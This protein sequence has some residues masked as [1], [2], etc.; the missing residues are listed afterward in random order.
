MGSCL[1]EKKIVE[2][3]M[4]KLQ[5]T[6][7]FPLGPPVSSCPHRISPFGEWHSHPLGSHT[8]TLYFLPSCLFHHLTAN[9]PGNTV[10]FSNKR[11]SNYV[12]RSHFFLPVD[13]HTKSKTQIP[14]VAFSVLSWIQPRCSKIHSPIMGRMFK[15]LPM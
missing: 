2:E 8:E 14:V 5:K 10:S 11:D 6:L 15:M 7:C 13:P 1:K 3:E 12:Y 4:E 9:F